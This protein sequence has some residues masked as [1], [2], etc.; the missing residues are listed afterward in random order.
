MKLDWHSAV[1]NFIL[2]FGTL[3]ML[4]RFF[5]EKHLASS[6]FEDC[7]KLHFKDLLEIVAMCMADA[8]FPT[9]DQD[10]FMELCEELNTIRDLR[11]HLA[12]CHLTVNIEKGSEP[13]ATLS[14][15]RDQD[16]PFDPETRQLTFSD[17]QD[18]LHRLNQASE[19]FQRLSRFGESVPD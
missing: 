11:N 1:G 15:P 13:E 7:R 14:M 19:T 17:L 4:V 6:D 2:N 18:G 10:A 5:L 12:H 9:S 8:G 3:E 16:R